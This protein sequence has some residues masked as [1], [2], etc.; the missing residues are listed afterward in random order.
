MAKLRIIKH[1]G[2]DET[3]QIYQAELDTLIGYDNNITRVKRA[4][5][6]LAR[7]VMERLE[8]GSEI[9]SGP[10]DAWIKVDWNGGTHIRCLKVR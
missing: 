4:R 9:E 10:H 3:E 7:S 1:N 8:K 2:N 5:S 6:V